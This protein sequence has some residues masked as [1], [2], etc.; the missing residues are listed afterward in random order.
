MSYDPNNRTLRHQPSAFPSAYSDK[1]RIQLTFPENSPHT[2]Q[3]FKDE[4]DINTI[5]AQYM[6]T[7]ELPQVNLIAPQYLELSDGL[8]FQEQM[9]AVVDA[10]NLFAELPSQIR[11]RFQNDPGAFIDFCAD[12]K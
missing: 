5:M 11:N 10:Q 3:E 8:S 9:Q 4:S 2:R 12:E 6:R 1:P 7:G